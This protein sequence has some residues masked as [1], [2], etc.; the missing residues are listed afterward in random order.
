MAVT[1]EG[2]LLLLFLLAPGAHARSTALS[3]TPV[4]TASHGSRLQELVEVLLYSVAVGAIAAVTVAVLAIAYFSGAEEIRLFAG[5][6]IATY[7]A[8]KPF[9]SVLFLGAYFLI[10]L[11]YAELVGA[12]RLANEIRKGV[13]HYLHYEDDDWTSEP[14]WSWAIERLR[15]FDCRPLLGRAHVA[16]RARMTDGTIYAGRLL[17][18]PILGDDER[19]KDFIITDVLRRLPDAGSFTETSANSYVL[20]NAADCLAIEM[21]RLSAKRERKRAR[22]ETVTHSALWLVFLALAVVTFSRVQGVL[23]RDRL[24]QSAIIVASIACAVAFGGLVRVGLR[25]TGKWWTDWV[26][27]VWFAGAF[28]VTIALSSATVEPFGSIEVG[29]LVAGSLTLLSTLAAKRGVSTRSQE[30]PLVPI[31]TVHDLA[32]G[33]P[34]IPLGA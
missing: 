26:V 5:Q 32:E 25:T 11:A 34:I 19:K 33:F 18:W 3:T 20:L 28:V 30:P 23:P 12:T 2:I 22:A 10:A 6:G 14:T 29:G 13:A 15:G 31:G 8:A 17:Q 24:I 4:A 9:V 1:V 21:Y 16:I 7:F 27:P